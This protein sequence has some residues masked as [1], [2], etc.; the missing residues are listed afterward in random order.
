MAV[1]TCTHAQWLISHNF[2]K[3][4]FL[5]K[6]FAREFVRPASHVA[7]RFSTH[8]D[9]EHTERRPGRSERNPGQLAKFFTMLFYQIRKLVEHIPSLARRSGLPC[10]KGCPW[11]RSLANVSKMPS[12]PSDDSAHLSL[13]PLSHCSHLLHQLKVHRLLLESHLSDF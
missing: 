2:H 4:I 12:R 13:L 10:W 6:R 11:I 5:R 3:A 9:L 8:V 1:R 7:E